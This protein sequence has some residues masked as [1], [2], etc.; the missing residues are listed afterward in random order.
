MPAEAKNKR[1]GGMMDR[2]NTRGRSG[3]IPER[4]CVICRKRAAKESLA[5][6]VLDPEGEGPVPDEHQ[7]APG[8]GMYVC[9]E[10]RCRE[11]FSRRGA[12]K[13]GKRR[14]HE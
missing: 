8:R 4:M 12:G 5:R 7:T 6:Y 11:A 2:G 10:R 13:K 1:F 3:H 14:K 9:E